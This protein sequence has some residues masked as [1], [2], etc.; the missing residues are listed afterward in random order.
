M[1]KTRNGSGRDAQ[2]VNATV[3]DAR[4]DSPAPVTQLD[5]DTAVNVAQLF[6]NQHPE[7][8]GQ[9]TAAIGNGPSGSGGSNGPAPTLP[10]QHRPT[11]PAT[12]TIPGGADPMGAFQRFER[13]LLAKSELLSNDAPKHN[14]AFEQRQQ[15]H[16]GTVTIINHARDCLHHGD[17]EGA[18]TA[19]DTL[20][21]RET[22]HLTCFQ[23]VGNT[24]SYG[25]QAAYEL[26]HAKRSLFS[27]SDF[28]PT[29]LDKAATE[30]ILGGLKQQRGPSNTRGSWHRGSSQRSP[31]RTRSP[32]RKH[33]RS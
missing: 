18:K 33:H 32:P 8:H 13:C 1:V 4:R 20:F 24:P 22:Y 28:D 25:F 16:V 21:R 11:A 6:L 9:L 14:T 7:L 27:R 30:L 31:D 12:A 23:H 10:A 3:A 2:A 17:Y 5:M 26:W 29:Q 15:L 19:L